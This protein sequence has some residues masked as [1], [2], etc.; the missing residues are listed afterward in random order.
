[1]WTFSL[2]SM[3]YPCLHRDP[4]TSSSEME[5]SNNC[6]EE[7]S[8]EALDLF[9]E[10]QTNKR[11]NEWT[12]VLRAEPK[13]AQAYRQMSQCT[14]NT[15]SAQQILLPR[16]KK[17][18]NTHKANLLQKIYSKK[19]RR[20]RLLWT[21]QQKTQVLFRD[22]CILEWQSWQSWQS[23]QKEC[24]PAFDHHHH[25][26]ASRNKQNCRICSGDH[27]AAAAAIATNPDMMVN[28]ITLHVSSS[29]HTAASR[30]HTMFITT[31]CM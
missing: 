22:T 3:C 24:S 1:M 28:I 13:Q 14:K 8:R 6:I 25:F 10:K 20:P 26:N 15:W 2:V 29:D 16:Q 18:L 31:R 23:W 12:Q 30:K 27:Q 7:R 17:T 9:P 11:M 4:Q 21:S 5:D 19:T